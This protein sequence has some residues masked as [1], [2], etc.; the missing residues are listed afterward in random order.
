MVL[1]SFRTAINQLYPRR[2]TAHRLE[3]ELLKREAEIGSELFGKVPSGHVRSFVCL[4][5]KTIVWFEEPGPKGEA[6]TTRYEIYTDRIE[7]VQDGAAQGLVSEEESK[8]LLQAM[9]WY[10]YLVTTQLYGA[11]TT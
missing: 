6:M 8:T 2:A 7:K 4:D 10:H 1:K 9:R 3:Q 11:S 5:E